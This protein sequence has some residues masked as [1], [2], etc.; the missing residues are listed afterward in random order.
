[1]LSM[2]G[3]PE[4]LETASATFRAAGVRRVEYGSDGRVTALEFYPGNAHR[5]TWPAA[6]PSTVDYDPHPDVPPEEEPISDRVARELGWL[7][8]NGLDAPPTGRLSDASW[9]LLG[10]DAT[11]DR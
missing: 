5:S 1:M 2:V 6:P 3:A 4:A 11:E 10:H 8:A 9:P 7:R